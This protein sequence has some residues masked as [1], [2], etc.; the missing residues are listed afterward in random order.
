[1]FLLDFDHPIDDEK[2]YHFD[3]YVIKKVLPAIDFLY[4]TLKQK[5]NLSGYCIGGLLAI[6]ACHLRQT[7]I[8]SVAL[9]ATPW[10]FD[11]IDYREF[12]GNMNDVLSI[13]EESGIMPPYIIKIFFTMINQRQVYDKFIEFSSIDIESSKYK[14]FLAIENWLNDGI[15][16]SINTVRDIINNFYLKNITAHGKWVINGKLITLSKIKQKVFIAMPLRDG[17]VPIG[18]SLPMLSYLSNKY[19]FTPDT[20]HIGMVVGNDAKKNLWPELLK[21][22]E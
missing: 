22:I 5:I 18:S 14:K 3:D 16:V 8:K 15:S 19:I 1:V 2:K 13:Y 7:A 6:A 4:N 9:L 17:I 21:W 11:K 20:G 10:D 12:L